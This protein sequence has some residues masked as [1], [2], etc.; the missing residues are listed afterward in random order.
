[1]KRPPEKTPPPAR[2]GSVTTGELLLVRELCARLGWERKTLTHAKRAGLQT[3]R[4]GRFDYCRGADVVAFFDGLADQA[5]HG[6]VE[7]IGSTMPQQAG[8]GNG[9]GNGGRCYKC[10]GSCVPRG[11]HILTETRGGQE[12]NG[13]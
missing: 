3:I 6:Q 8:D 13:Q 7:P 10:N 11:G 12:G 4:F 2:Y 1:M 9:H 5:G